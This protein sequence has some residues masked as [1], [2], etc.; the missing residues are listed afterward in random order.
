MP[1]FDIA[2]QRIRLLDRKDGRMIMGFCLNSQ[3]VKTCKQI[4][5]GRGHG[6]LISFDV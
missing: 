6:G 4:F 2:L 3:G 5:A 1:A